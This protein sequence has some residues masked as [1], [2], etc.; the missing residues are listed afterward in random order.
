MER[1]KVICNYCNQESP[2][3]EYFCSHDGMLLFPVQSRAKLVLPDRIIE[4]GEK[5]ASFGKEDFS[6]DVPSDKIQYIS[7]KSKPHFRIIKENN[8]FYIEDNNSLNGTKVNNIQISSKKG[9]SGKHELRDGDNI[10]IAN[11]L[12]IRFQYMN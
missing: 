7:R 1:E 4:L 11:I 8:R 5:E 9:G 2:E 3:G 12:N 6:N 10:I